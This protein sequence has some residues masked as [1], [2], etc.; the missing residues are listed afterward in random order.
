[1]ADHVS[2]ERC[3]IANY[4]F[5]MGIFASLPD[6]VCRFEVFP[7]IP[8]FAPQP[9]QVGIDARLGDPCSTQVMPRFGLSRAIE[10][11]LYQS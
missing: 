3:G 10:R 4:R 11:D 2:T 5:L 6:G 7:Q 9:V 8:D 1:M